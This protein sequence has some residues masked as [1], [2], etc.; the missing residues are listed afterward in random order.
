MGMGTVIG[1][2]ET[3]TKGIQVKIVT[4]TSSYTTNLAVSFSRFLKVCCS[5]LTKRLRLIVVVPTAVLPKLVE[6][7]ALHRKRRSFTYVVRVVRS[8]VG[9]RHHWVRDL[10]NAMWIYGV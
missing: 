6:M 3:V 1:I 10:A 2:K 8:S 7:K 5:R 4:A 9:E